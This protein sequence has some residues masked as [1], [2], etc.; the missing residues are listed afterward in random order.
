MSYQ[1]HVENG[2]VVFDEPAQ[3]A[4]GTA[5]RVEPVVAATLDFWQ[6][7]SLDQLAMSQGVSAP[8]SFDDLVGGWPEDELDDGFEDVVTQWR[9]QELDQDW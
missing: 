7:R 1:G 5:V 9:Q 2:V 3:L 4:E 8:C 6:P